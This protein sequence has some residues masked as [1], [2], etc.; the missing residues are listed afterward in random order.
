MKNWWQM[1]AFG[2]VAV[3]I[4]VVLLGAVSPVCAANFPGDGVDGPEL[5]YRDNGD[6]TTTDLNTRLMW[7]QKLLATDAACTARSRRKITFPDLCWRC[8]LLCQRAPCF[9]W[10]CL[11]SLVRGRFPILFDPLAL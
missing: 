5:S 6:G 9:A 10:E 1:R 7:E 2:L 3:V 4:G 8:T 11:A